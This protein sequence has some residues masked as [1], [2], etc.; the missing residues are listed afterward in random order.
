[1]TAPLA[2]LTDTDVVSEVMRPRPVPR[3][4]AFLD[5][6]AD[7]G[8]GLASAT[9]W[10]VLDGISQ[11]DPG[12]RRRGTPPAGSISAPVTGFCPG[13]GMCMSANLAPSCVSN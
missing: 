12:R 13:D 2:W 7:E 10:E 11:L 8:L 1:M 4:A 5:S 3:V 6:I 9:V